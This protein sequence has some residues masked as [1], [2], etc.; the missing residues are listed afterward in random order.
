MTPLRRI[1]EMKKYSLAE[2]A[3]SV[4][5][6]PGNLSRI[7][8]GT[9]KPS[10]TLAERLVRFFDF[11]ITELELL[12]PERYSIEDDFEDLGADHEN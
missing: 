5:S 2:V 7:E 8:N 4:S 11:E 9:Q 1:R 12:Y 6:D 3:T 10:V